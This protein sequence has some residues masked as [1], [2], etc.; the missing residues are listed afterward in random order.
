MPLFFLLSGYSLARSYG[1]R[2]SESKF[3]E[4]KLLFLSRGSLSNIYTEVVSNKNVHSSDLWPFR[5]PPKEFPSK[6]FYK[7]RLGEWGNQSCVRSIFKTSLPDFLKSAEEK[8]SKPTD[9][10]LSSLFSSSS[11]AALHSEQSSLPSSYALG[12]C[13][14]WKSS[15]SRGDYFRSQMQQSFLVLEWHRCPIFSVQGSL[16]LVLN[17]ISTFSLSNTWFLLLLGAPP[18]ITSWWASCTHLNINW[19]GEGHLFFPQD[20]F[21]SRLLLPSLPL[22]SL[23]G[24][25]TQSHCSSLAHDQCLLHTAVGMHLRKHV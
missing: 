25:I 13:H 15:L 12:I 23:L 5:S 7:A 1:P 10:F 2:M 14:W 20:H 3:E 22:H 17:L 6:Y 9:I 24:Q 16:R 8:T 11:F 4:G 21:H 18:S 19:L